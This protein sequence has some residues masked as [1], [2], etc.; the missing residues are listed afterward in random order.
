MV[1]LGPLTTDTDF[2]PASREPL[3]FSWYPIPGLFSK[4][5]SRLAWILNAQVY[6]DAIDL[7]H[8]NYSVGRE[9]DF[10]IVKANGF[11]I[12]ILKST[13]G[14][15]FMDDKFDLGWRSCLDNGLIPLTYH[16]N[17]DTVDGFDQAQW[18]LS[19]IVEY[20]KA[21]DG[22]TIIFGDHETM[23][24]GITQSQRG[25]RAKAFNETIVEEG[26]LSGNYSSKNA[27]EKLMGNI[28]CSWVNEYFQWVANWTPAKDPIKPV[29]W[30]RDDVWQYGIWPT[31]SWSKKV[32]T[33]GNV[34]VCRFYGTL[35]KWKD[36]LGITPTPDPS[37]C[38]KLETELAIVQKDMAVLSGRMTEAEAHIAIVENSQISMSERLESIQ[39]DVHLTNQNVLT[40]S[41]RVDLTEVELAQLN[42]LVNELHNA[43]HIS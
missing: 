20:L 40:L 29:G 22:K 38:E 30:N 37:C 39:H 19:H 8:W 2:N 25:N 4:T 11:D 43:F 13:E 9:P 41:N 10:S 32:G 28:A 27:W 23:T 21:V 5:I 35:Q 3:D 33:D 24:S 6:V 42:D 15:W 12:V 18:C 16:F 36:I 17:R 7:S 34:D 14:D 31:Y 1:N 26:F